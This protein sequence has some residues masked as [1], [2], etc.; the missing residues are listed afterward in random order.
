MADELTLESLEGMGKA[1]YVKA[2]KN[3]A[4][5]KKAKAAIFLV[6]YKLDGKKTVIALPFKKESEMKAKM[7]E[8]KKTKKHVLKK[9]GGGLITVENDGP[10]GLKAKVELLLGGLNPFIL[11]DK[12]LELFA[13]INATLEVKLAEGA[14][15]ETDESEDNISTGETETDVNSKTTDDDVNSSHEDEVVNNNGQ[16]K[17]EDKNKEIKLIIAKIVKMNQTINLKNGLDDTELKTAE[18]IKSAIREFAK[19]LKTADASARAEYGETFL[20]TK[21]LYAKIEEE[22]KKLKELDKELESELNDA[23]GIGVNPN[24]KENEEEEAVTDDESDEEEDDEEPTTKKEA[25][26]KSKEL[27]DEINDLIK[28]VKLFEMA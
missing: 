15:L 14:E 5:W 13:R 17:S 26:A 21:K 12:A 20:K 6:D 2:F 4:V 7:K 8:I 19:L 24:N 18:D 22:I 16:P 3:K 27:M 1:D 11:Q 28:S 25:I 9:T 10:E 23:L